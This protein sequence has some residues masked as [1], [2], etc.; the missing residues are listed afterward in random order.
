ME[1]CIECSQPLNKTDQFCSGCGQPVT[2]PCPAC[3]IGAEPSLNVCQ[4]CG[5]EFTPDNKFTLGNESSSIE[6]KQMARD[7]LELL[8]APVRLSVFKRLYPYLNQGKFD[9]VYVRVMEEAMKIGKSKQIVNILAS[10]PKRWGI[11][12]VGLLRRFLTLFLDWPILLAL[13]LGGLVVFIVSATEPGLLALKGGMKATFVS[14]WFFASYFLYFAGTEFVLG[15]T[16]GGLFCG[17]RVVD[18]FGSKQSFRA[19]FKRN[20]YKL[21][22][23]IGPYTMAPYVK[24]DHEVVKS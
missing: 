20:I 21:I 11:Q 7:V 5:Y 14:A 24:P 17:V 8:H 12:K 1:T 19:L 15:A 23:L 9:T 2:Q 18:E 13:F 3:G 16:I 6:E 10:F 22:P 4:N